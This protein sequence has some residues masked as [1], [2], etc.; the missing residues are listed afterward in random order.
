MSIQP[1]ALIILAAG[2]GT[3]MKSGL[4]KVLHEVCGRS[5][6][7]H[8]VASARS[9]DA[10]RIVVVVGHARRRVEEHLEQ[11]GADL[12]VAVQEQQNGTGHAVRVALEQLERR[13]LRP[14][15][16]P[17]VVTAGDAPLLGSETLNQL[18]A[19]HA[20]SGAAVTVLSAVLA[21][22][23]G[24]GRVVRD[25]DG[26]VAE[27]VEHRDAD[28]FVLAI[29]EVNSGT[30]VFDA[31]FLAAAVQ[32]LSTQNAQGE[33]YLTDLVAIARGDDLPVAAV[34]ASDPADIMGVN[35]RVQL[36]EVGAIMRTRINRAWMSAGVTMIDPATTYIDVDV[37]L[38]PDCTIWPGTVLNGRTRIAAGAT[39]GPHSRL[40]DTDVGRGARVEQSHCVSAVIGADC[41]IGPFARL[42]PGTIM[43]AG[44]RAGSYVEIKNSQVGPGSK[45]PHLSYVGDAT[46]GSGSNIGAATV[47]VNYDG[48][49]KHSTVIGDDVRIGSDTMLVAPVTVGDGAYTAA[50]S[51]VTRDVPP[52]ALA[53]ARG[54]QRNIEGWV[55][56]SRPGTESAATAQA[57]Q[58]DQR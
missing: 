22:P 35:N 23:T 14:Q 38:E 29:D 56:A 15:S 4:P 40:A 18:L 39:V 10:E 51:V 43:G 31:D 55:A 12:V 13:G 16:G 45:V 8:V 30:Y 7:G 50:G 9:I 6:V 46:I 24:Y 2:E 26:G 20:R 41:E 48:V 47:V 54:R 19:E 1:S 5:L 25:T 17:V 36:A 28:E 58:E 34:T 49:A 52:G 3:R 44:A 21:D 57:A 32:R 37:Q 42:R 11:F 33:E 53:I 27:I